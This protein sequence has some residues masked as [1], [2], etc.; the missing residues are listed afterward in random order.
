[1]DGHYI[2]DTPRKLTKTGLAS[3]AATVLPPNSV[4]FSSRAPIGHTA[5]NTVPMATNQGFKSLIPRRELLDAQFL[6]HWLRHNRSHLE[7]LGVGATFKEV[8]KAIVSR[9]EISLPPLSEQRR[10]AAI[11]DK[12][13]ALRTKRREA[14]AQLDRLSQSIFIEMFGGLDGRAGNLKRVQLSTIT[15]RITDGTHLTPKFRESGVPFIFVK[16]FQ[17]G[18]IDFRTDKFVSDEDYDSLYRRCPV[19]QGDVLYTTVGATY[20]KAVAVGG[21]TRFAFQR[22]VAHLKPDREQVVPQYLEAVMQLPFVKQQADRWA[23]GAAQPT[24]NLTELRQ[25]EI[26]LPKIDYQ[27]EFVSRMKVAKTLKVKHDHSA[28]ELSSLFASLQDLAFRGRL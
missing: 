2:A 25:F 10:I 26:P 3:C 5:I 21:F 17:D 9:V 14:L 20:G 19:E 12:S 18:K 6:L 15:T 7:G 8:S 13:D 23:R 28:Q 11:L 4:L 16:N 1:L 24:I 22:H 27:V